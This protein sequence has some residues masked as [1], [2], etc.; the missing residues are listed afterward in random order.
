MRIDPDDDR[1]PA[2]CDREVQADRDVHSGVLDDSDAG[3]PLQEA[4]DDVGGSVGGRPER[5]D[6]FD[7]AGIFLVQDAGDSR[8]EVAG[9]VENRHHI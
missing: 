3:L 9:F 1:E 8:F 5:E 2:G 7:L 4:F 6:Q